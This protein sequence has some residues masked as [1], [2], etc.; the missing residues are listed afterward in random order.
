LS[1]YESTEKEPIANGRAS[2]YDIS[3]VIP[4]FVATK[5]KKTM[6]QAIIFIK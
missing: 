1:Q 5:A 2:E 4:F 3:V 6:K